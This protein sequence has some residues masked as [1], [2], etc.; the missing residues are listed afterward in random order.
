MKARCYVALSILGFLLLSCQKTPEPT[1]ED[2]ELLTQAQGEFA[3]LPEQL[4]DAVEHAELISLGK[5]LYMET[6]LSRGEK[7]SCNSCHMLDQFGVDNLKT[8]PGHDGTFGERNSPTVY[9]SALNFSQFWDGRAADLKEQ[10][11]GP[12]LNPIEHG[13]KSE[14]EVV[15]I[16]KKAGY[17]EQFEKAFNDPKA[18][19]FQ[20]VGVAIEAFEKTLITPSRFDDY[21]KGDVFA[22]NAQER[23]GLQTF[24]DVGCTTCHSGVNIGG[25]MYQKLGLVKEYETK[26][27]GRFE[28]TGDELDLHVFKVPTL[29]N[30]VHT[31]PYLHDG[32]VEELS[33][34]IKIMAEYQL[35]E[36]VNDQQVEDIIAFLNSMTGKELLEK[37]EKK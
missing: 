28:V 32:H 20:N 18:L 15:E 9:N 1:A 25:D 37:A 26:D 10:A 2:L 34:V 36:E 4:I 22:L 29:R 3:P 21:L 23:R 12:L 17:Q 7:I 24:L 27:K 16:L 6:K 35:G 13:L 31:G 19:S 11:L 5:D 14:E 33:E 30:I 8:S